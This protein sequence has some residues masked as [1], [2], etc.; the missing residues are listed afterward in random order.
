MYKYI[1]KE[2]VKVLLEN[3]LKTIEKVYEIP[4]NIRRVIYAFYYIR[5]YRKQVKKEMNQV[6]IIEDKELF[7]ERFEEF[8]EKMEKIMYLNKYIKDNINANKLE[9]IYEQKKE[10]STGISTAV[11][12]LSEDNIS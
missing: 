10:P 6:K 1:D 3:E 12:S 8:I 11:S 5:D 2:I 4:H 7:M 9:K